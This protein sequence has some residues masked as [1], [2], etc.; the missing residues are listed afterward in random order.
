MTIAA[1][2][3][4]A[5]SAVA[6][7][8]GL[9]TG[10]LWPAG[11]GVLKIPV[12]LV[13]SLAKRASNGR[14]VLV[15]AMTPTE[16]GE[17][18]TV[19]AIGLGMALERLGH[20]SVVCLRQP[21]LGPVF[22]V[23]G[24]ASGGGRATVHPRPTIDLG[25]SGDLDAITNGQ[26]LIA[27]LVDHHIYRGLS[28]EI[29]SGTTEFPRASALEDRS[30]RTITSGLSE[31]APGFPRTARFVVSAA[32]EVAAIHALARDFVDLKERCGRI[33]VGRTLSGAPVRAADVGAAGASA[34]LLAGALAPNLVQTAEGTAALVHGI[35]YANVAHGT[36]S[37]LAIEAGLAL[38]EYCVV[39]AGFSSELGAEKFVDIVAA[40]TG[41]DAHVGVV[42]A[43]IRALRY[44]GGGS[45]DGPA[46]VEDVRRG[47]PN[48]EQHLVNLKLLGLDPVVALNKFPTDHP[49]ECRCVEQFCAER[50]VPFAIDSAFAEGSAGSETLA[51]LVVG[52]A[53][54]QQQSRPLYGPST[55]VEKV[56]DI[57]TTR[58]YGALG[59]DLSPAAETD[60]ERIRALGEAV[61]PVCIA[62]TSRSLSDDP[63]LRGRPSDFRVTVHRFERWSG[64][65][66]TVALL[67]GIITMP[68]LP[69]RPAAG[70]ID[71][72]PD[73]QVV[74][75][76]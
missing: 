30:L 70:A 5:I 26:N 75:V 35:P 74:G 56:L 12:P 20:S 50:G 51:A 17:G 59:C 2:S 8:L 76:V 44:H 25:L 18:K 6:D 31:S 10:D 11:A 49:E 63:K 22:G 47:L 54:Q 1:G 52:A 19:V 3:L 24:G 46:S 42:V 66:F 69:P 73:G 38:A 29:A 21:S 55:P 33:L 65:G 9:P 39:E 58:M 4:R 43:S 64:A 16:H 53:A 37:R 36:C 67:G 71:L 57:V 7:D 28:P 40:G 68:G 62:K 45:S 15:S 27:S 72:T 48:L 34:S 32:S 14:L 61:G 41:L 23:K 60:L 13:R